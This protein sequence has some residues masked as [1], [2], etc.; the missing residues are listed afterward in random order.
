MGTVTNV[1]GI[2][3]GGQTGVDR[4]ALDVAIA[5]GL[6]YGGWCPAGG[7]AEDLTTPPGLLAS[8]PS[9]RP[10]ES[11]DPAVRSRLNVRDSDATLVVRPAG[12]ASAG[13]DAT[14]DAARQLGRPCLVTEGD[15]AAVASWLEAMG[16]RVVLNVAGPR[17]SE[18]PGVHGL[19][20]ALL[21]EVVTSA[22]PRGGAS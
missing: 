20:M 15:A 9:L 8:Y 22:S 10:T 5:Q 18:R 21:T 17:E 1:V 11:A 16:P 7:W 4:A 2:V 3:S 19:A 6:P 12:V 13:T 14:V